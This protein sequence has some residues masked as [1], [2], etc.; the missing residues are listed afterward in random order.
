MFPSACGKRLTDIALPGLLD[1]AYLFAIT[2][3]AAWLVAP[4]TISMPTTVSF[5]RPRARK[6]DV[7]QLLK[8]GQ[9]T[10]GRVDLAPSHAATSNSLLMN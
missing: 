10:I 6:M 4:R 5:C 7:L 9:R 2:E 8:I 3:N 1:K